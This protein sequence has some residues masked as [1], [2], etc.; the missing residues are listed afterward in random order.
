[1]FMKPLLYA[2]YIPG[3]KEAIVNRTENICGLVKLTLQQQRWTRAPI[4]LENSVR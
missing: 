4:N 3:T 2:R 1:M